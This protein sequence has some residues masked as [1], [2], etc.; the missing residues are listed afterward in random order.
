MRRK[1]EQFQDNERQRYAY[2]WYDS[3]PMCMESVRF[4]RPSFIDDGK[5]IKVAEKV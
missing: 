2:V 5:E 4:L 3:A 1:L